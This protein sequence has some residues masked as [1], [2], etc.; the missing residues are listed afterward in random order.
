L[1]RIVLQDQGAD[2]DTVRRETTRI[3]QRFTAALPTL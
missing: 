1:A 3:R 2:D